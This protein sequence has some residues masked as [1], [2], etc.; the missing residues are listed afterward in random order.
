MVTRFFEKKIGVHDELQAAMHK[1]TPRFQVQHSLWRSVQHHCGWPGQLI[2]CWP[3]QE[4]VRGAESLDVLLAASG[5]KSKHQEALDRLQD[6]DSDTASASSKLQEDTED[7]ST[8][9]VSDDEDNS[10]AEASTP[11]HDLPGEAPRWRSVHAA[12]SPAAGDSDGSSSQSE[13]D[14]PSGPHRGSTRTATAHSLPSRATPEGQEAPP[15]DSSAPGGTRTLLCDHARSACWLLRSCSLGRCIHA[16]AE[17][18]CC[19]GAWRAAQ[20]AER[21]GAPGS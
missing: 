8:T 21:P 3:L 1:W 9:S 19:R 13:A 18:A 11:L 7:S 5:F 6:D 14:E 15:S 20:P 10:D 17:A 12:G 2:A 4:Q 16:A